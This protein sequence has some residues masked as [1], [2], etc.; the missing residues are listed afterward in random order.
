LDG[1][2][3]QLE[4]NAAAGK[5]GSWPGLTQQQKTYLVLDV[6]RV[7]KSRTVLGLARAV[8][9]R[10]QPPANAKSI[11]SWLNRNDQV[12]DTI[13]RGATGRVRFMRGRK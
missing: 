10:F 3:R 8:A 2:T 1:L 9:A 7:D 4:F 12:K 11:R 5:G 6:A 13:L